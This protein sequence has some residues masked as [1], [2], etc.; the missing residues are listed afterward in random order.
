MQTVGVHMIV[1]GRPGGL[2]QASM[3]I[4]SGTLDPA[5]IVAVPGKD[6]RSTQFGAVSAKVEQKT[7]FAMAACTES[8][9]LSHHTVSAP[10]PV[11]Q[12]EASSANGADTPGEGVD[13]RQGRQQICVRVIKFFGRKRH[14]TGTGAR[15]TPPYA[16]HR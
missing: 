2:S 9:L 7:A 4:D 5:L 6:E 15:A 13:I 3:P 12:V 1:C 8:A 11:S 10:T 16:Q 14:P